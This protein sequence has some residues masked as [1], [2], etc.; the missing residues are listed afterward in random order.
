MTTISVVDPVTRLEGHLKIEVTVDDVNGVQ[1]VVDARATGTLFRG[2][3]N[4]LVGR[5]PEDA[6]HITQRICGVCPVSHG[7]AAVMA[8][9]LASKVTV[10]NNA[11]IMRNLVLGSNFI[12]S[13][14]LHFYHLALLDFVKGPADMPPWQNPDDSWQVDKRIDA[15]NSAAA[16]MLAT[17]YLTALDMR[18][19]AHEMGSLFGGRLPHPPAYISGGFTTTPKA[20]RI[21]AFQNYLNQIIPFI[22][23]TYIPDV[24]LVASFYPEYDHQVAKPI[25]RGYGNLLAYGVFDLNASGTSKLLK[26]GKVVNGGSRVGSVNTGYITEQVTYSWYNN[27]TNNLK[28]AAGVTTPQYPKT[29][30]YSWLKAPRYNKVPFEVG[31]LARMWVNG[32]YRA[33]ISVMDRHR[34]RA[35]EALKVAQAMQTWVSQLSSTGAVYKKPALPKSVSGVGLTEAPR[36]ALGHWLGVDANSKIGR[37]QVITPT[38]WNASPRDTAGKRGPIEQAL[39]GTPVEDVNQPIEVVRVIHSFD[40]CLSCAVHVL[41]PGKDG[42]VFTLSHFHGEEEPGHCN[43]DHGRDHGHHHHD[44]GD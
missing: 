23:N 17:H 24:D 8:Q 15:Q 35:L 18:R 37:Y 5:P 20:S 30:A 19:Q 33:G 28:P 38:C 9:D 6:E 42:Q 43:H 14:I 27:N 44:H 13:H 29:G 3:E 12:A 41:R 16:Q 7:M 26:R 22:S 11:R 31:P 34:A 32:D 39:I 21:T 40:P 4:I 36:G 25:G 10:P 1:Q 2:F